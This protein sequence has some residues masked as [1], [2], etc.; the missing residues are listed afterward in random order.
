ML[1]LAGGLVGLL[2]GVWGMD[3][4]AASGGVNMP[5]GV[6]VKLDPAVFA[7]AFGVT[8]LTGALFGL[9]PALRFSRPDLN[10]A[11]KEGG[12]ASSVSPSRNRLRSLL[13]VSQVAIAVVL[14]TGA[15]LMA[16]SFL[17]YLRVNPGFAPE[18][19]L[20]LEYRLPRGKYPEPQR[21]LRFHE[22]A[23][24]RVAALPG[25]E[26]AATV[27]TIPHGAGFGETGFVL[28][29]RAAPQAGREPRA[30]VNR[31]GEGY[32][33]TMRIPI[34]RGRVFSAQDRPDSPPAI[35]INQTMARRY[36]PD[37]DP[38][39]KQARL[40]GA[41]AAAVIIGV[42]GDVKNSSLDEP[43]IPQIYT[44]YA[45]Q[46]DIFASMVVRTSGDAEGFSNAVRG[47]IW[48]VDPDQPVW[49]VRTLDFL[50]RRSI[51][52]QRFM[53]QLLGALSALALA[54]SAAG[55]YGALAY[56]VSQRT[57]EIGVRMALGARPADALR[58]IVGQGMKLALA[59]VLLGALSA[60]AL[61]HWMEKLLFK[62]RAT[63][64][65]TFVVIP[66]LLVTVALLACWIPARRASR[67]DPMVA[68]R[69]E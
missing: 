14:L 36:W 64:P 51:G 5:Y 32:F 61:T 29:D 23:V 21:Q 1:S 39:G 53:A 15:G 35:V 58:L 50:L 57:H 62:V 6:E 52:G 66:S 26:S 34:L 25:V 27:M 38:V 33:R 41:D 48:S 7:F 4:I 55:I 42:V 56:A 8:V 2:I 37:V 45:Q 20:T 31:V 46:P 19:V 18:N 47:A 30:Q 68:L 9:L 43:E 3:A 54:L 17:N 44:A 40:L 67:L 63:D 69:N 22:Q 13:V 16:R 12:R 49:K 11:L 28:P 24:A 65:L 59:G 60:F 10:E